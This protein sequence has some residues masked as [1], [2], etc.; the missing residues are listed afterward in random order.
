MQ[1]LRGVTVIGILGIVIPVIFVVFSFF[2]SIRL[3][4]DTPNTTATVIGLAIGLVILV[5][6]IGPVFIAGIGLLRAK[7]WG[8]ILAIIVAGFYSLVSVAGMLSR[9]HSQASFFMSEGDLTLFYMGQLLILG[10]CVFVIW[11][12]F[13]SEVKATFQT[14][15]A[16]PAPQ[17]QQ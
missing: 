12:L 11:Y 14:A 10:F 3:L 16:I 6:F 5:I 4:H 15:R 13:R 8:R 17:Q 1:R 9:N 7:S 2:K